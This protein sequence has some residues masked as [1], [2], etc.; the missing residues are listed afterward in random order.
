MTPAE[1]AYRGIDRQVRVGFVGSKC[2]RLAM[3]AIG[4]AVFPRMN[5]QI[6]I[7]ELVVRTVHGSFGAAET[8][9]N[10]LAIA[11]HDAVLFKR[12]MLISLLTWARTRWVPA[13]VRRT[14]KRIRA[15]TEGRSDNRRI[16]F[17][18]QHRPLVFPGVCRQ[19]LFSSS[20]QPRF[21]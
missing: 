13:F 5:C 8:F 18:D 16:P 14:Y 6:A 15:G 12:G 3:A 17:H 1:R 19:I 10:F 11:R 21:P 7:R 2:L 20:F 9:A 4:T